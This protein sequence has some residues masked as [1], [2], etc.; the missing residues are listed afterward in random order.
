[1]CERDASAERI[2]DANPI[3]TTHLRIRVAAAESALACARAAPV[4]GRAFGRRGH[5]HTAAGPIMSEPGA[6]NKRSRTRD[7]FGRP[8]KLVP[9]IWAALTAADKCTGGQL[10]HERRGRGSRA[11]R[12]P[13]GARGSQSLAEEPL[14]SE[15]LA[16]VATTGRAAQI[17]RRARCGNAPER[18]L[19]P[20]AAHPPPSV[21]RGP[22]RDKC[23]RA[24][25]GASSLPRA[26]RSIK[27]VR[28]GRISLRPRNVQI[29]PFERRP[30]GQTREV[31]LRARAS[32][33]P[34]AGSR[35]TRH[36]QSERSFIWAR[37]NGKY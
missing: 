12:T 7:S 26:G 19:A 25:P 35:R 36:R 31:S 17:A 29:V 34:L 22:R 16:R 9:T 4:C 28:D 1:M 15:R 2:G 11:R 37:E 8:P 6:P 24:A 27:Q 33:A 13:N 21:A 18:V 3:R 10:G 20:S 5:H 30:F 14:F 23:S 32:N